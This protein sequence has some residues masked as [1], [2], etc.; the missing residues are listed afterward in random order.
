[1]NTLTK[2]TIFQKIEYLLK[3]DELVSNIKIQSSK[4]ILLLTYDK[5]TKIDGKLT[6]ISSKELY[7]RN[8]F[9][10]IRTINI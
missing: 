6:R 9:L 7:D 4:D 1:M 2:N 8:S 5:S 10:Y 3:S